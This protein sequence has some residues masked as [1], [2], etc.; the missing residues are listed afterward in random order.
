MN[1]QTRSL[2]KHCV[3][4]AAVLLL[5][6]YLLQLAE[7]GTP[8]ATITSFPTAL[9]Y[10]LTT[11][12]TVGYGDTYPVTAAGRLIGTVF[13]VLSLG[14]LVF[15]VGLI[16]SLMR[17]SFWPRL[18]LK[19]SRKRR[20]HLFADR[21]PAAC[22][23]AENI[24]K[25]DASAVLV[26]AGADNAAESAPLPAGAMT[27]DLSPAE[28]V[29]LHKNGDTLVF[30]LDG[31]VRKNEALA[32]TL[33]GL[34]CQI[35]CRTDHIP[36]SVP[37][38]FTFFDRSSSLAR[39]YWQQYPVQS[40]TEKI[41]LIGDGPDA[42]AL[43]LQALQNNVIHA[44]SRISYVVFGD[45]D[46]F[47]RNHPY[48]DQVV[49]VGAK[50]PSCDSLH[51]ISRP[52]NTDGGL[53]AAADRIIL[54]CRTE[55]QTAETA[56]QL[57]TYFPVNGTVYARLSAPFS[58]VTVFGSSAELFTPELVMREQ[59]DAAARRLHETY[60]A[61]TGTDAPWNGL[62][63]FVRRSNLASADHLREKIRFLLK[64]QADGTLSPEQCRRAAEAFDAADPE[65][66]DLCRRM[67]HE[68]WMRFH[69]LN[70]WQYDAVRD[71]KKR[72]HPMIA[73]FDTLPPEDR[74]KDDYAWELIKELT[75]AGN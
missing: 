31:D 14:L 58:G 65:T 4:A 66:R 48:L 72:R 27:V 71:N 67:E 6:V 61:R 5:L 50:D 36:E 54:C 21:S 55:E 18:R 64:E 22:S 23:L 33:T 44:Y 60:C 47:R 73:P 68:R 16:V 32:G 40:V 39:L 8:D 42:E 3:L 15:L 70:N 46:N 52:W 35:Y 10:A 9:W 26:F 63:S 11:L 19:A 51:F 25:E 53:L 29:N 62:S 30:L 17:G 74:V 69:L 75:D 45:F 24:R 56:A 37:E 49:T 20:W 57:L 1:R 28:L 59:L 7:R 2:L 41:I 12:T 43:L 13:Q 34:S 38:Q